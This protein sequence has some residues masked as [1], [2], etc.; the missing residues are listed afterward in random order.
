[1]PSIP[2][3][4]RFLTILGCSAYHNILSSR[5]ANDITE[6]N[7]ISS[8]AASKSLLILLQLST[9]SPSAAKSRLEL[10]V[11]LA[12]DEG[13]FPNRT[14]STS[15]PVPTDLATAP[16][17]APPRPP[18]QDCN[19]HTMCTQN[20]TSFHSTDDPGGACSKLSRGSWAH[21]GLKDSMR[22]PIPLRAIRFASVP[23]EGSTSYSR[24]GLTRSR[25]VRN[26]RP[27]I[28]QRATGGVDVNV[29]QKGQSFCHAGSRTCVQL[30]PHPRDPELDSEVRNQDSIALAR[31]GQDGEVWIN[32]SNFKFE[33]VPVSSDRL[34]R[35]NFNA[36]AWRRR[37]ERWAL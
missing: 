10:Y 8:S 25:T 9:L 29:S 12:C 14:H 30:S 18:T 35:R 7:I 24:S 2:S 16:C 1:M 37:S 13:T 26:L 34:G 6:R 11:I 17:P 33:L 32:V 28:Q 36:V 3:L 22:H 21:R 15:S 5:R 19:S 23:S 4:P 27:G 31:Q 20:F